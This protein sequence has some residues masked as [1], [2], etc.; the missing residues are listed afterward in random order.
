MFVDGRVVHS[1][2]N[3][4]MGSNAVRAINTYGAGKIPLHEYSPSKPN[5]SRRFSLPATNM[6]PKAQKKLITKGRSPEPLRHRPS[7]SHFRATS[8]GSSSAEDE[9]SRHRSGTG[10]EDIKEE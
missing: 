8:T 6:S 3:W 5:S 7:N 2:D 10:V 1:L 4:R 9:G